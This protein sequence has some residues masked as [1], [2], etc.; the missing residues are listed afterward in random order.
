MY[1]KT[2]PSIGNMKPKAPVIKMRS[3][4][5]GMINNIKK[6]A[7]SETKDNTPVRLR[8]IGRTDIVAATVEATI[9]LNPKRIGTNL[10]QP[11]ILG[12][13]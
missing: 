9:S 5:V 1:P 7:G 8:S 10:N 13:T 4:T 2:T 6:F 3:I 11:N 12:V